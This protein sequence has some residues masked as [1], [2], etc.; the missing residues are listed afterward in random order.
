MSYGSLEETM[1]KVVRIP[2]LKRRARRAYLRYMQMFDSAGCGHTLLQEMSTTAYRSALVF[3]ETMK[4]LKEID[5][6]CPDYT[7]L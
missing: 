4:E 6:T 7:P 3:N 5:S 1:K 2:H